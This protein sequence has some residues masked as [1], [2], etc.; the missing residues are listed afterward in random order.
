MS[1]GRKQGRLQGGLL[2]A[3]LYVL[4]GVAVLA[5]A[6]WLRLLNAVGIDSLLE[7]QLLSF[8]NHTV[9]RSIGESI[10][11][12][13]LQEQGNGT[14]GKFADEAERQ[15]LRNF[16]GELLRKLKAAGARIVAFDLVFPPAIANCAEQNRAFAIDVS[17]P[18]LCSPV[19]RAVSVP[20]SFLVTHARRK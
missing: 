3:S 12:V 9:N 8:A 7:R 14:V 1:K 18:E 10:R 19:R 16:H 11:L 6:N 4:L 5:A 20:S 17:A 2:R 13:Y 15:C